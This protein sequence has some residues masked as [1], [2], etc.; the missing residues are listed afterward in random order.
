M[1]RFLT[2]PLCLLPFLTSAQ[3]ILSPK[4]EP[5]AEGDGPVH[6]SPLHSDSSCSSFL[7]C[8]DKSIKPHVHRTH[9]EHV[10]VLEGEGVMRL[11]SI[12]RKVKAGDTIII[13]PNTPHSVQVTSSG[14]L[15][16]V[17]VQ[18]PFFDGSD[19]VFVEP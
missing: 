16:V 7:I 15:R 14:S 17:S 19:R 5:C 1:F 12:E 8:I 13:P 10:F 9:T 4:E 18:A 3:G 2:L 11:G 6:I